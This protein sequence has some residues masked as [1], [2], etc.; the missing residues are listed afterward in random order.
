MLGVLL[1]TLGALVAALVVVTT[2]QLRGSASQVEAENRRNESYRVADSMR[3][4]SDDLTLM[5]RLYVSTGQTRYREYFDE[6]LAIRSGTAPRPL[7]YDTVFWARV[8]AEGQA[9]VR[10]GPPASLVDQMR[11]AD[12]TQ[13][14]F[15]ALNASLRA[16]DA[17]ARVE[18]EVMDRVAE[19]IGRG[20]D[21]TY[22]RDVEA[23]YR[24]LVDESYLREKG[25]IMD[26][27]GDFISL[28]D[29]RTE[30]DVEQVR[31]AN[32]RWFVLQ[33]LLLAAMVL[34][35]VA[36]V[37]KV[38]RVAL[39]PLGEL[40]GA[41]RRIAN[42][43]YDER[44]SAEG[45]LELE[46]LS[47]AFNEMASSIQ[48][49]IGRRERAERE[50]VEARQVAEY[51]NRA[52]STFLASMSHEIRT[53]M[54]G[55]TGMLE[56]LA[57]TDL[58]PEQRT[59][60]EVAD[61]SAH[62][63]LQIIGD[64]LDFSKIEAGKLELAPT[65]FAVRSLVE[66]A[67]NNFFH[68]A[69]A[70]GLQLAWSVDPRLTPAHIGDPLRIRQI[71][72]NFVSNAVKFTEQGGIELRAQVLE[73]R[74]D[75]QRVEFAVVDTGPGIPPDRL[76]QLFEEFAQA[77]APTRQSYRGTGLGLVIC[78]RLA[79]L[80]DGDVTMDSIV[81]RGTTVRLT[82]P[83]AVGDP[84]AIDV[85]SESRGVVVG[86]PKPS[87]E[88]A[89]RE[90][91]LLL[92]AEDHP[93]NRRVLTRQLEMIGFHVDTA[94]D[95]EKALHQFRTGRYGLVITDVNMPVMD[96][97]EL[98][99]K[100]REHEA[101]TGAGRT[102]IVALSANVQQ[103]EAERCMA[104]GM[105]DF[106]SKPTTMTVL[107]AKLKRWLPHL[108]WLS[109][110]TRE[111][112]AVGQGGGVEKTPRADADHPHPSAG[113]DGSAPLEAPV[114]AEVLAELTGGDEDLAAAILDDFV[115][116]SAADLTALDAGVAAADADQV[117]RQA[118]R[119]K[120]A[121]RTVGAHRM[122]EL[123]EQLE[124][125]ATSG[126]ADWPTVRRLADQLHAASAAVTAQPVS[127]S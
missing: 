14:E 87:R 61:E 63:L 74:G 42:G 17:L 59:M 64:I 84:A 105:D 78:R 51:A 1:G 108:S 88:E 26:A 36:A 11:A 70:T 90:G 31:A 62:I 9:F 46:Q 94:E 60:A 19:R 16:S 67:A 49:D 100:I 28:V 2:L 114:D 98:A 71:I 119:I 72:T 41:A 57:T 47:G 25:V 111:G 29:R 79:L 27:I 102:P 92:L 6:I 85:A 18:L 75:V 104:Q 109:D 83:L 81:G 125:H 55:V 50:A 66:L 124:S 69:S 37:V 65:T 113:G 44:A 91:S 86:R 76:G 21:A 4:S 80:M 89:E 56:V 33:L 40:V 82:V 126:T 68:T 115:Q 23:D 120:G 45:V 54:I 3:Q 110:P 8:L 43:D 107:A 116:S 10:Y 48:A 22:L 103:G 39:R 58:T 121:S 101:A 30:G 99:G 123:A 15:D 53:P 73:D 97:C 96:G 5:V 112:P 38:R 117:R 52:K 32:R 106:A 20:V 13:E 118:H 122:A 34:V 35:G 12:F 77:G 93:V 95:G 7:D 24:R 127:H